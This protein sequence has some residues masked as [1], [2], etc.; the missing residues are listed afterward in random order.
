M[1]DLMRYSHAPKYVEVA[2]AIEHEIFQKKLKFG[3]SLPTE[4]Q[5]CERF[6]CS[7]GTVRQAV[8]IL[9]KSGLVQRK[10]G[11][12]MFVGRRGVPAIPVQ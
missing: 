7:R 3:D 6:Q 10:Q 5:L 8:D 11:S 12:G 2:T 1:Y 9:D 4:Q